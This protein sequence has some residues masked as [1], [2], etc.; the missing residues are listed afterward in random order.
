MKAA[1]SSLSLRRERETPSDQGDEL[2][3]LKGQFLASL[4]HEIRTPLSGILGMTDLL[5]ETELNEEQRE[6][7]SSARL[8]AEHLLALFNATLEFSDLSAGALVLDEVDFDLPGTL[9]TASTAFVPRAEAKGLQLTCTLDE[10]LPDVAVGDAVRLRQLLFYL[11]DNAVK[12]THSGEVEVA[13]AVDRQGGGRF[14]LRLK[15]RDTG[16][17]ITPNKLDA[18]FE[19]FRQL[20]GGLS[21]SYSGLGLGLA[22]AQKLALLMGGEICAESEAGKGSTFFVQIPLRTSNEHAAAQA[23]SYASEAASG[24]APGSPR[25]L[26]V[27][28]NS[29]AQRVV[30]HILSRGSYE[31]QCAS[32]GAEAIGAALNEFY[33]LI[34]MDLQMPG[35]DG[36]ETTAAVRRLP[37]YEKIPIIALTANT[38]DE[39]RRVC[40]Q[41]GMQGFIAKPVQSQELLEAIAQFLK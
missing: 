22:L 6:Y 24:A 7:A 16:I 30:T 21:R 37:G 19:S 17:G 9:R 31:F 8:C 32:S 38:T 13:A 4:N 5:L 34:L 15:V 35:M 41:Q 12:F 36:I 10:N 28:D 14:S 1:D 33:D 26:V 2:R 11:L 29:V 18:I 3:R 23:Q 40:L 25:I 27:E 20:D 39:Y